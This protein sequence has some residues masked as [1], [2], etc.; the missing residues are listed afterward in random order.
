[1]T[2]RIM[3]KRINNKNK[4]KICI[5]HNHTGLRVENSMVPITPA[6]HNVEEKLATGGISTLM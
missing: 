3:T 1:M 2:K 4:N 5:F 6:H